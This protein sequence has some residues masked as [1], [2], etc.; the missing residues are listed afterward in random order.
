MQCVSILLI[1]IRQYK[2]VLIT[3]KFISIKNH[4]LFTSTF[5]PKTKS[6]TSRQFSAK[7]NS[8]P[9]L[10]SSYSSST[11]RLLSSGKISFFMPYRFAPIVFY[12]TPPIAP[13]FPESVIQPVMPIQ[14][15]I[16][17][18]RASEIRADVIAQPAEGPSLPI[19]ISGKFKWMS[20]FSRKW[21][22]KKVAQMYL[23][24]VKAS[25]QLSFITS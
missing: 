6:K 2:Y 14:C 19:S 22:E 24:Y 15:F 25:W 7:Q 5:S 13:A 1:N 4:S 17:L 23:A 21:F 18:F 10:I 11:S 12:L 3:D 8:I 20:F 9:C 16:G